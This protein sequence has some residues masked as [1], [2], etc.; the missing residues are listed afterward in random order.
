MILV[1]GL[2][3][4]GLRFFAWHMEITYGLSEDMPVDELLDEVDYDEIIRILRAPEWVQRAAKKDR[5]TILL[6]VEAPSTS[7]ASAAYAASTAASRTAPAAPGRMADVVT[8]TPAVGRI[9][10]AA[11][12]GSYRAPA[13]DT[14]VVAEARVS[15][16]EA[17][18]GAALKAESCW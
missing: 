8:F 10:P 14:P 15:E 13:H 2:S 18:L 6:A 17:G 4:G 1:K 9:G 11:T 7:S 16:L 5:P 12:G 3:D